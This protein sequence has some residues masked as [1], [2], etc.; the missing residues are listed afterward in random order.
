MSRRELRALLGDQP[1]ARLFDLPFENLETRQQNYGRGFDVQQ[2]EE[3]EEPENLFPE[4]EGDNFFGDDDDFMGAEQP[5]E[6]EEMGEIY[7]RFH[8]FPTAWHPDVLNDLEVTAFERPITFRGPFTTAVAMDAPVTY[9][10]LVPPRFRQGAGGLIP[11]AQMEF[12]NVPATVVTAAEIRNWVGQHLLNFNDVQNNINVNGQMRQNEFVTFSLGSRGEIIW[13]ENPDAIPTAIVLLQTVIAS[14]IESI[15]FPPGDSVWNIHVLPY[16]RLRRHLVHMEADNHPD[17]SGELPQHV[18]DNIRL[19]V[20]ADRDVNVHRFLPAFT[21]TLAA[22]QQNGAVDH[23][24]DG[25]FVIARDLERTAEEQDVHGS[26]AIPTDVQ[27]GDEDHFFPNAVPLS[28]YLQAVLENEDRA[29]YSDPDNVSSTLYTIAGAG[30]TLFIA[31]VVGGCNSNNSTYMITEGVMALNVRGAGN[32]CF[33][34][35]LREILFP[36]IIELDTIFSRTNF[37]AARKACGLSKDCALTID[38][39]QRCFEKF[40]ELF[41][42]KDIHYPNIF[43]VHSSNVQN[44]FPLRTDLS[45]SVDRF[46]MLHGYHYYLVIDLVA[47]TSICQSCNQYFLQGVRHHCSRTCLRCNEVV[48][49]I[50]H[51]VC[52]AKTVHYCKT[53]KKAFRGITHTCD[54][55]IAEKCLQCNRA[56]H[57]DYCRVKD[58]E[59]FARMLDL[60]IVPAGLS[61]RTPEKMKDTIIFDLE[62][63]PDADGVHQVYAVAWCFL[64]TSTKF[65][66]S[67]SVDIEQLE[68]HVFYGRDC[69]LQ[70]VSYIY[71]L[72][73]PASIVAFNGARFDFIFLIS[74]VLDFAKKY[75]PT[76]ECAIS[77]VIITGSRLLTATLFSTHRLQDI[78]EFVMSSLSKACSDFKVPQ[79]LSKTAFPHFFIDSWEKLNYVGPPPGIEFYP[80]AHRNDIATYPDGIFDLKKVCLS[81]LRQDVLS[82][83]YIYF[84]VAQ[85]YNKTFGLYL[86]NF[87][88]LGQISYKIW[89]EQRNPV[90]IALPRTVNEESYIR[91]AFFGGRCQVL[92]RAFQ[93]TDAHQPFDDIQDYLVNLDVKSLYPFVMKRFRY[94]VGPVHAMTEEE[95]NFLLSMDS[96]LAY[97]FNMEDNYYPYPGI[98]SV[99]YRAPKKFFHPILPKRS[100]KTGVL[101][102]DLEDGEGTFTFIDLISAVRHGYIIEEVRSGL[103]WSTTSLIFDTFVNYWFDVKQKAEEEGNDTARQIAKLSQNSVFGKMSQHSIHT[104]NVIMRTR[105]DTTAFV[106]FL[107]EYKWTG[108]RP[109]SDDFVLLTGDSRAPST[110]V[111]KPTQISAFITAFARWYMMEEIFAALDPLYSP[112]ASPYYTDTDCVYVHRSQLPTLSRFRGSALGC[113]DDDLAKGKRAKIITAVFTAPKVY[114]AK[115]FVEGQTSAKI[116]SKC[117]GVPK[118]LVNASAEKFF[119]FFDDDTDNEI[120]FNFN[121]LKH[122]TLP[123]QYTVAPLVVSNT[124]YSRTITNGWA[125]RSF[126]PTTPDG[127]RFGI[128][129][130]H[131]FQF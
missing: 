17:F 10:T 129:Y 108:F 39:C 3:P 66:L 117:K 114:A 100:S 127:Q 1:L 48:K 68:Y 2:F 88:T 72:D 46:I 57:P 45:L 24:L 33:F 22:H 29:L 80:E 103:V 7:E 78:Y 52:G 71:L 49:N 98:Y 70:F 38:Q 106:A 16:L 21:I 23:I 58:I 54:P 87:L 19:G 122:T 109:L 81:Y 75:C 84:Q 89:M 125:G 40:Y 101:L 119:S 91:E 59:Y 55:S 113:L 77:E 44:Q 69:L 41:L 128:F 42:P 9:E 97:T 95:K 130:P 31:E 96:Y 121:G 111:K 4:D 5:P 120:V 124:T 99:R 27:L 65:Y 15:Q 12:H 93:S 32:N 116:L 14:A 56:K 8:N 64:P 74:A 105:T 115:Y 86:S 79:T 35:C 11:R 85:F 112:E 61:G 18:R 83:A 92:K 126:L 123:T 110:N 34:Y 26:A 60:R 102:W 63:F 47:R 118:T 104:T 30:A 37:I 43:I 53:C 90:M 82:A 6:A 51:H 94:P 62:T 36:K 73:T 67:G 107:Q 50:V 76:E 131:G 28:D 25:T 20:Y 13:S